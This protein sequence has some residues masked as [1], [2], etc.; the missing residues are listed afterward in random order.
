MVWLL[1]VECRFWMECRFVDFSKY[2]PSVEMLTEGRAGKTE[3]LGN[4][5]Y[6]PLRCALNLK[7]L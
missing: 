1:W 6:L 2:P 5:L 3:V 7:L 4:S